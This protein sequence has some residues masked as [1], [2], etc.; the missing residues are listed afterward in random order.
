MNPFS[1]RLILLVCFSIPARMNRGHFIFLTSPDARS[2]DFLTLVRVL[3]EFN[4]LGLGRQLSGGSICL[5]S[6]RS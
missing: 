2:K 4:V 1:P 5:A 3:E 6:K